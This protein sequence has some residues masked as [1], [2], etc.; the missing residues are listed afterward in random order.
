MHECVDL[1]DAACGVTEDVVQEF[2]VDLGANAEGDLLHLW[3]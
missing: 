1:V 3:E 2:L